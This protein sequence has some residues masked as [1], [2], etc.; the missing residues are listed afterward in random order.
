MT[1]NLEKCAK[2]QKVIP[3]P[4]P[5]IE[6]QDR[7]F[8]FAPGSKPEVQNRRSSHFD[9]NIAPLVKEYSSAYF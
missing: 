8:P 1:P 3:T 7:R 5:P 9:I 2:T 6:V 4:F